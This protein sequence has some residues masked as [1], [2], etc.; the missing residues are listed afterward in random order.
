[1]TARQDNV[2]LA[3]ILSL[4]ALVLFDLMGLVIKHL[5]PHYTAA[6]L[7]AYR[8]FFGL[9]PSLI[10]LWSSPA[11]HRAG[12]PWRMRQWRLGLMRG[13]YVTF[14]QFLFYFSLGVMPF[15]TASTITYA[16]ALFT[17][18]LAIPLLGEK[19]GPLRWIAVA[20]GFVGVLF[21]M[22]PG[23]E[24]FSV[25]ALAPLGA[26]FLYAM[27]GV[28]ARLMDPDVPS[29]LINLYST[30]ASLAGALV[31]VMIAGGFSPVRS[32]A[33]AAWIVSMGAFGGT[34]V[35]L[36]V[37]SYRMT[38]QS[39]LAPFSYFGIPIAFVAGWLFFD[40]TPWGDLFPGGLLI[41]VGGLIVIWRERQMR[42]IARAAAG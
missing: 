29:P 25:H 2:A 14:A 10:A 7:S 35:L 1:M 42:R 15:A 32:M 9:F 6:E 39:N 22:K 21:I 20:I 23:S 12:R 19:V 13:V 18:A 3:I 16:N 4:V 17:T 27:T 37:I 30:L 8:N 33:D 38:E 34:A 5:S 31:L 24:S 41:A 40:E 36:L 26:A 11:W 28:T